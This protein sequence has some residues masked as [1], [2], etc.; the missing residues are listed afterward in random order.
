MS[1]L[2]T[3]Q[4]REAYTQFASAAIR[5]LAGRYDWRTAAKQAHR[6]A[7]EMV[8]LMDEAEEQHNYVRTE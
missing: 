4:K 5:D 1:A 8:N 6:I 2:T 7:I 3:G